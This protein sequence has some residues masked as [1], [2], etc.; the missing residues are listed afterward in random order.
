MRLLLTALA[1]ATLGSS[2]VTVGTWNG[3]L[4]VTAPA[5]HD[6]AQLGGRLEQ[7][8]SLDVRDQ[9]LEETAT[10]L[11]TVSGLNVVLDPALRVSGTTVTMQVRDMRLGNVLRWLER[12]AAIHI[13]WVNGALFLSAQ[14][15]AGTA[16]TRLYD[17]SDLIM[18][19]RDFQGPSLQLTSAGDAA[20]L[21][22]VA[23]EP[24]ARYDLDQLA[25]L[26]RK[27]R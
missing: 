7:R 23:A 20:H 11:H 3:M 21:L 17:V 5:G 10:F 6:L 24:E 25:E 18:P 2:E 8:I 19:V 27:L 26:V 16:R 12:T 9:P 4:L 1:C 15:I 13:G 14:P 22:P